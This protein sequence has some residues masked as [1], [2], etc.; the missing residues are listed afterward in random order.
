M[1][2]NKGVIAGFIVGALVGIAPGFVLGIYFL[3][4]LIAE[5]GASAV[6]ISTARENAARSGVFLRDLP[7][8][9]AFHWGEGAIVE[10]MEADKYYYTLEGSLAPG[11]DYKLYLT[12]E[13]V[14]TEAAFLAIKNRSKR[15]ASLRT[16]ENFRVSVDAALNPQQYPAIV[17]WCERFGKFITAAT[18]KKL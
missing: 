15:V 17:V 16:F 13:Y 9:D 8:S 5:E 12:P 11:P 3:P 7:G 4:I 1:K 18:L 10:S 2:I 14:D 6:E